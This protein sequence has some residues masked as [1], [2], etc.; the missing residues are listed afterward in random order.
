MCG[1]GVLETPTGPGLS[2]QLMDLGPFLGSWERSQGK[3]GCGGSV[4]RPKQWLFTKHILPT[5]M[6]V[7]VHTV[8]ISDLLVKAANNSGWRQREYG[9][10]QG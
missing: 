4:K 8:E 5:N 6:L 3:V 1:S 10:S 2:L 7:G 9:R